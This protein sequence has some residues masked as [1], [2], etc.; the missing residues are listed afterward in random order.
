[1]KNYKLIIFDWDGTLMDSIDRIV[2]S[3]Q[4][5]ALSVNIE[6]PSDKAAKSIIGISLDD[7]MIE[8]FPTASPVIW[9]KAKLAYKEQYISLNETPTQLFE[10]SRHLLKVLKT[11][12]KVLAV[13]TGKA[14]DGLERVWQDTKTKH[15]F[16][17]SRCA[18]ECQSKPHPN[19]L[20]ELLEEL[21][22]HADDAVMIGD[23]VHDLAMA[24]NAG[25]DSIGVT[26]GVH[27]HDELSQFK[28]KAIVDSLIALENL[29][30]N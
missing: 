19:M 1:M 27:S 11:H 6:P 29:L 24:K 2:S 28:P 8:L 22:I 23:T 5:A 13:A 10:H 30:V 15:F 9:Q 7:A 17:S 16:S 21:N 18:V 20:L 26:Y 25:V 12:N 14:R 4:A 3:L